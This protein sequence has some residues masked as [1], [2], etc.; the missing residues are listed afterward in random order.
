MKR[1]LAISAL[2]GALLVASPIAAEDAPATWDGLVQV[3]SNRLDVVFLQPGADFRTYTKVMLDPTEVAFEKNW[4]R[5]Y[6]RSASSLSSRVNDRDIQDAIRRGIAAANDIFSEAWTKG[7][8]TVVTEAGPDVLRVR[9]GVLNIEVNAPDVMT[10]GRTRS[11][12]PEAGQATYFVEVRDSLTG[13]LL[14]RA[15]D[16]RTVGD[17]I[18]A[19]RNSVTN[20]DDFRNEVKRWAELSVRG[21]N[22][23]KALSPINQ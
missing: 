13:A 21:M 2:F 8:Y 22:E 1:G 17:N 3:K 7:G 15:A 19:Y 10:A 4:Q 11:F 5:D 6:N 12:A 14:G 9:P 23:L 20:R 16:Q 18:A